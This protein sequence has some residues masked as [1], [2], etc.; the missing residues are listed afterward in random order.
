[1]VGL[2]E[3]LVRGTRSCHLLTDRVKAAIFPFQRNGHVWQPQRAG[4]RVHREREG[5]RRLD[6][7]FQSLAQPLDSAT[8]VAT[9]VG[10]LAGLCGLLGLLAL[11]ATG[12][13]PIFRLLSYLPAISYVAAV[14][15][16]P[17]A[18]A[19]RT[20]SGGPA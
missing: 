16:G 3:R 12:N 8:E 17:V 4:D 2:G 14:I 10:A 18:A 11:H 7:C 13:N 9:I 5:R 1:L 20:A 15:G 19:R 6:C